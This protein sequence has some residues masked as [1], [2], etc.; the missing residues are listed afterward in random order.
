MRSRALAAVVLTLSVVVGGVWLA[1]KPAETHASVRFERA[2]VETFDRR[3]LDRK[4]WTTCYWWNDRGCT[5]LGNNEQQ[6]YTRGSVSIRDGILR[7]TAR[8]KSVVASDG[9][10]YDYTSG[11]VTTGRHRDDRRIL[12]GFAFQYGRVTARVRMPAGQGLW[13]AMWMLPVTHRSRPEIDIFEVL[14]HQPNRIHFH[15]HYLQNGKRRDPGK[16]LKGVDASAGWHRYGLV[17]RRNRLVWLVDGKAVWTVTRRAAIPDE[18]MYLL[19]NLA[20]GGEWPGSPDPSTK[21]P[22][23]MEVDYVRIRT[24]KP[25]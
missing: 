9:R 17:W 6:W 10:R 8:R 22:A 3:P 25:S 23:V 1:D 20:V 15:V 5:N 11:M 19:I 13:P 2:F 7:L 24:R 4:V 12:P 18:P 16:T 21:F 14:G